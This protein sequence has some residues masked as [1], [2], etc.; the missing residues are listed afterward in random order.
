MNT[1]RILTWAGFVVIIGLIIWG[2]IAAANKAEREKVGMAPVDAVTTNDWLKG[3]ASS[4]VALIEYSD[5][6]CPAC[7]SYFPIVEK[8]LADY[9]SKIVFASRHFPLTQH[10]NAIPAAKASEAAGAQGKFWEMHDQ[11]F[12]KQADWSETKDAKVIF[13]GYAEKLGLDMEKFAKDYD[14]KETAD[15]IQ[16][17]LKS[18]LKA[19]V[20]STPTFYLNGKKIQPKN[21][22]EFKKLIDEA[23]ATTTN[24]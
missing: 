21:Y 9:S 8:V 22:D 7:A 2:M 19:G 10:L 5:F 15:K 6:Q 3:N 17:S 24:P 16:L 11:L 20:D 18:G 12:I 1:N 14:S 4:T 13:T 23:S